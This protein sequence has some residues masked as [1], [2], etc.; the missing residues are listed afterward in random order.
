MMKYNRTIALF[1]LATFMLVGCNYR[2]VI[3]P[4][5]D[6]SDGVPDTS[7][8][9]SVKLS[10]PVPPLVYGVTNPVFPTFKNDAFLVT[11]YK[12]DAE[13]DAE[14]YNYG[15]KDWAKYSQT[16]QK[17][18]VEFFKESKFINIQSIHKINSFNDAPIIDSLSKSELLRYQYTKDTVVTEKLK[19]GLT[20]FMSKRKI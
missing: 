20:I 10:E 9:N 18:Q 3:T 17:Y 4:V 8:L 19:G 1:L 12:N 13:H 15:K 11:N 5:L 2:M 6:L 14:L 7:T 16:F